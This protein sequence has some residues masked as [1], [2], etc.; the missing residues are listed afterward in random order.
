M[1]RL[2]G[3]DDDGVLLVLS[4]KLDAQLD[5]AAFH[6][7]V[8]GFAEVVEQACALCQR[9][10]D[11][12][13]G[14]HQARNVRD[15]NG[16][17][18]NVLAVGRA[19]FL[20]A[21][22]LDQL[23]VQIV[24]ARFERGAFALD[25]DGV[26]D[27]AAGLFDHVLNAGRMDAAVGDELF[28]R[29]PRDLA[30]DGI[31]RGDGDGL[32]GIVD[33]EVNAGDGFERADVAALA[34]DD[35]ALHF[36]VGQR[37]DGDGRF[38]GMVCR[39]ALDGGG[40]DLAGGLVGLFLHLRFDFL[41]LHRSFVAHVVFDVLEDIGLGFVL[42][43]AGDLFQN[44]HLAALERIDLFLLLVDGR[45]LL[46]QLVLFLLVKIDLLVK[47]FFLLLQTALLLGDF[48]A[49]LLDLLLIFAA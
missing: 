20:A 34:A 47:G 44:L 19:V 22:E 33:D 39:A 14:R 7:V 42:R 13:L 31:E 32:R 35:A 48:R 27:L 1:V 36:I 37:D 29:K 23:G 6:L 45:D 18:Q 17:V 41:D 5:V 26:V 49:A 16:V 24:H 12:Q 10:V 28:K 38:G 40:D 4:G 2:D 30:A 43:Q 15:L 46:G 3:V 9:H 8:D 25:L 21:Q 11:A